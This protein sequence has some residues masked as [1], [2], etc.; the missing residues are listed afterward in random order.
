MYL[1]IIIWVSAAIS[2]PLYIAYSEAG[3]PCIERF[4]VIQ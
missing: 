4:L 2:E 1:G 3:T